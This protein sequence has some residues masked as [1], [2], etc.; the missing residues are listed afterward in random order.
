MWEEVGGG[1]RRRGAKG[2][3]GCVISNQ[4]MTPTNAVHYIIYTAAPPLL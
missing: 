2:G 4:Y 1:G 3:G